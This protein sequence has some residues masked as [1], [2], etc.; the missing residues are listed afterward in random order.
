LGLE[1]A[2]KALQLDD[3]VPQIYLSPSSLYLSQRKHQAATGAAG[4]TVE[5]H[6]ARVQT[7]GLHIQA[8]PRDGAGERHEE[9]RS[10]RI[11]RKY[12]IHRNFLYTA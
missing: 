2:D 5:V 10:R 4:R 6:P 9:G 3:S 11:T 7:A 1:Y 8:S 12:H